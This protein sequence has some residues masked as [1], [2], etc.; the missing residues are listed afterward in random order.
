MFVDVVQEKSKELGVSA[1]PLTCW[2]IE[3]RSRTTG[4][5]WMKMPGKCLPMAKTEEESVQPSL[6]NHL[7]KTVKGMFK[8]PSSIVPGTSNPEEPCEGSCICRV[9]TKECNC[10]MEMYTAS[11]THTVFCQSYE[12][13]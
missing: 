1:E 9:S 2:Y 10:M 11:V 7:T 12:K 3:D 5:Y 8:T 13:L 4:P 6:L